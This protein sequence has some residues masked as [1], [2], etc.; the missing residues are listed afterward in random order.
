[1]QTLAAEVLVSSCVAGAVTLSQGHLRPHRH[2]QQAVVEIV[3]RYLPPYRLT[4]RALHIR[5]GA[6]NEGA[7]QVQ[8]LQAAAQSCPGF[9]QNK[10]WW[11]C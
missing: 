8:P 3:P 7:G 10:N 9:G 4:L 2:C 1:M 11:G 6:A 5:A